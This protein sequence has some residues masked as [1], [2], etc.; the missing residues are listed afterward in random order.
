MKEAGAMKKILIFADTHGETDRCI[1]VIRAAERV[2][3]VI[4][5][6]DYASDAEDLS[7]IFD[8]I[9]F[10]YVKGN[11]DFFSRAPAKLTVNIDGASVFITH[12]HEQRVKYESDYRTLKAFAE[13]AGASL[14]VFGHTHTPYCED[15]GKMVVVNPGSIRYGGTYALAEVG[16]A[17]V[18]AKIM[19]Y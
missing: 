1:S 11:N 8:R 3:A 16:G 5:A 2:D 9:P 13:R 17:A 10:F 7:Y 12:G 18:K 4:H 14:A 6:G 15:A 19:E